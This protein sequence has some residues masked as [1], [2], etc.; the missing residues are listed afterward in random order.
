MALV[1]EHPNGSLM[2]R[3]TAH[4]HL[5]HQIHPDVSSWLNM[6]YRR[7]TKPDIKGFSG[8]WSPETQ[9]GFLPEGVHSRRGPRSESTYMQWGHQGAKPGRE[10]GN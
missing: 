3:R 10:W 6:S 2:W 4:L 8:E 7:G 1:R 9:H 5:Q